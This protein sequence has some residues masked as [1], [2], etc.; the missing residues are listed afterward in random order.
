MAHGGDLLSAPARGDFP[1]RLGVGAVRVH[2]GGCA[3]ERISGEQ[4]E[5]ERRVG[6]G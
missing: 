5:R 2:N 1:E 3:C 4:E 6:H